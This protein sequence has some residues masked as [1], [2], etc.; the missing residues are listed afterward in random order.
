MTTRFPAGSESRNKTFTINTYFAYITYL[1]Y[2][3]TL[4]PKHSPSDRVASNNRRRWRLKS[5]KNN[6]PRI[7]SEESPYVFICTRREEISI[8]AGCMHTLFQSE[9]ES[10]ENRQDRV[11][12]FRYLYAGLIVH[13][14]PS[15]DYLQLMFRTR[16]IYDRSKSEA[17]LTLATYGATNND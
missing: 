1:V 6:F 9:S 15:R 14:T 12:K 13:C 5:E 7:A 17:V 2:E 11:I 3:S 8:P 10:T 4:F 16:E